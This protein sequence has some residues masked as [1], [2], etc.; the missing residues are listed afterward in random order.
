MAVR[1]RVPVSLEHSD[2]IW[3]YSII[4][5]AVNEVRNKEENPQIYQV[6]SGGIFCATDSADQIAQR[7][8]VELLEADAGGVSLHVIEMK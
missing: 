8:A 3:I 5:E 6:Q 2:E 4:L 7:T 1:G